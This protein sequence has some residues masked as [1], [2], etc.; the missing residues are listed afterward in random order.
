MNILS[1]NGEYNTGGLKINMVNKLDIT[2]S[3]FKE[4]ISQE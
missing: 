2:N 4:N 1:N 3:I